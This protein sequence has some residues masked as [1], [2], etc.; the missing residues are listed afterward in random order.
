MKKNKFIQG[1]WYKINKKIKKR[2]VA[3]YHKIKDWVMDPS[4]YFLIAIDREKKILRVGYCKFTKLGNK[5]V[6][7][8]VSIISG[9]NAI[10]IVNTLIKHKYISSLQHAADMGI[11]LCKAELA[12]KYKLNYVQDKDLHIK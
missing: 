7:D 2:I 11:E 4:G 1:R 6:N 3:K 10:E 9:R 12:L 8:M 5:P